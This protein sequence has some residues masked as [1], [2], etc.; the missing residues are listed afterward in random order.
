MV[1]YSNT[2][3]CRG[4]TAEAATTDVIERQLP[5]VAALMQTGE[6]T[7]HN[8]DAFC[9]RG[10]FSVEQT[11]RILEAGQRAGLA[12]NFHA[13]ELNRLHSAEVRGS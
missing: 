13:E 6:L 10:V 8:I 9:E 12:V 3:C 5:A 1:S 2:P 7:V 4:S 11:R